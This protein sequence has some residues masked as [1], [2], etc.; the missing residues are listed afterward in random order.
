MKTRNKFDNKTIKMCIKQVKSLS[1]AFEAEGISAKEVGRRIARHL[2]KIVIPSV[3]RGTEFCHLHNLGISLGVLVE[4]GIAFM[5]ATFQMDD[6]TEPNFV[7]H[8]VRR[9]IEG[10]IAKF[11][12]C[13]SHRLVASTKTDK[14]TLQV[15]RNMRSVVK[16]KGIENIQMFVVRV[17]TS[18][19]EFIDVR[20]S[21]TPRKQATKGARSAWETLVHTFNSAV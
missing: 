8:D 21:R 15:M 17:P 1:D 9:N 7:K 3:S 16:P 14:T 5:S 19:N 12:R 18:D 6:G 2:N 13:G 20:I 10:R 4:N 11:K